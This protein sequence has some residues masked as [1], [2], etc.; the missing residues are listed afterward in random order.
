M[1]IKGKKRKGI[2]G[3]L[4]WLTSCSFG[5]NPVIAALK[6]LIFLVDGASPVIGA[7]VCYN[8]K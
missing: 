8:F 4:A 1:A 7:S 6:D 3:F 2:S 5:A